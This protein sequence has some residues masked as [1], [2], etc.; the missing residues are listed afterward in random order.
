[1]NRLQK[2]LTHNNYMAGTSSS[3]MEVQW[4]NTLTMTL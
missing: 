3:P 4:S 2:R 1:M